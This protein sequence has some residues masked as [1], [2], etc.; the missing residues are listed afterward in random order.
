MIKKQRGLTAISWAIIIAIVAIEGV[1]ALRIIPS[2]MDFVSVKQVMDKLAKDPESKTMS[3]KRL[4]TTFYQRLTVSGIRYIQKDKN[5]L[6]F[7]KGSDALT[8]KIHYESRGRIYGNLDFLATFDHEI[9][10]PRH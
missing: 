3:S 1:A 4:T 9:K 2:Y 5:A 6:S 8:M 7:V 10:I